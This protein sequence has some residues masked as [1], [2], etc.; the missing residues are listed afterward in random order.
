MEDSYR[1]IFSYD[2]LFN[3]KRYEIAEDVNQETGGVW[4][5][6]WDSLN[7]LYVPFP[8]N[9]IKQGSY[10]TADKICERMNRE[11]KDYKEEVNKYI[12]GQ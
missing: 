7:Q 8:E 5:E 9:T 11:Y 6:V 2:F 1:D 10:E 12:K 3:K 4:Y